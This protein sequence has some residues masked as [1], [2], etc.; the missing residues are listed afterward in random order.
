MGNITSELIA[1]G[2]VFSELILMLGITL[3]LMLI[4]RKREIP[5]WVR[6]VILV[7]FTEITAGVLWVT[8]YFLGKDHRVTEMALHLTIALP[9][10]AFVIWFFGIYRTGHEQT[11]EGD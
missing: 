2:I 8:W 10:G 6:A 1:G 4:N 11:Q 5:T 3:M 9:I 7:S